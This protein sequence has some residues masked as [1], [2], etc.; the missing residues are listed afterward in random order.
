ML[1]A[2]RPTDVSPAL[3]KDDLSGSCDSPVN[4]SLSSA[5]GGTPVPK[6]INSAKPCNADLATQLSSRL[7]QLMD[8]AAASR[9]CVVGEQRKTPPPRR[10][11]KETSGGG[12]AIRP[13]S[14]DA[15]LALSSLGTAKASDVDSQSV[16]KSVS[17][18]CSPSS[19]VSARQD[20]VDGASCSR[21]AMQSPS[22][23]RA[24]E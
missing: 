15:S 17:S 2:A 8:A 14:M 5:C 1:Q 22:V 20:T 16:S 11:K 7:A 19:C 13:Q 3:R 6:K 21:T 12:G 10:C 9:H 24:V 23:S 4:E 18:V